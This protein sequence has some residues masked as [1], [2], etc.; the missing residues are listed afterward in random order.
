MKHFEL[1]ILGEGP[2][3]ARAITAYREAGGERR[4][5]LPSKDATLPHPRP[6]LPKGGVRGK[7]P[8]PRTPADSNAIP[9]ATI[10]VPCS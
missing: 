6:P 3:A 8:T 9:E 10:G 1:V 7:T 2:T 5:T 4:M